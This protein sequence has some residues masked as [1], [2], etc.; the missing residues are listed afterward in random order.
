MSDL[1]PDYDRRPWL[2]ILWQLWTMQQ[3]IKRAALVGPGVPQHI[4]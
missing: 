4:E 1:P 3:D 2:L